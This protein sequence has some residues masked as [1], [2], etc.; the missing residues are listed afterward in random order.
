MGSQ[1]LATEQREYSGGRV[2]E[3]G[4]RL[5]G[6][7]DRA[8]ERHG[9]KPEFKPVV[10]V[11]AGE[12]QRPEGGLLAGTGDFGDGVRQHSADKSAHDIYEVL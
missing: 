5:P 10:D 4:A 11:A 3:C 6:S 1:R 2:F 12:N 9:R 8:V 7:G